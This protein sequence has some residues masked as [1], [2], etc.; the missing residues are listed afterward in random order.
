MKRVPDE[1]RYFEEDP[2]KDLTEMSLKSFFAELQELSQLGDEFTLDL[3]ID[4]WGLK[5]PDDIQKLIPDGIRT[6]AMKDLF[7]SRGFDLIL[8]KTP[9]SYLFAFLEIN[10]DDKD[11]DNPGTSE[12]RQQFE[13]TPRRSPRAPAPSSAAVARVLR[14]CP[15]GRA[16]TLCPARTCPSRCGKMRSGRGA[17]CSCSPGS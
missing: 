7:S 10:Q 4:R 8:E 13:R 17:L 1:S 2:E 3:M 16:D 11:D 14:S 9:V 5:I 15:S 12:K 6:V